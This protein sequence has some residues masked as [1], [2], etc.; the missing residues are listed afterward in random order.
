MATRYFPCPVCGE[1]LDVR[2]AKR[3]KPY[4]VCNGCGVQMFVRVESGIRK[5]EKLVADA[6]ANNIWERLRTLESQYR[7][8]CPKCGRTFWARDDLIATSWFDGSFI[9]YECPEPDCDG[10]AKREEQK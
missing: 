3:G 6:E 4:V 5:F 7:R 9:G 2:K 10:I 8:K 1:G